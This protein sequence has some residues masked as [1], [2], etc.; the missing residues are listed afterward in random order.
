[1]EGIDLVLRM[2]H[3]RDASEEYWQ[4][5]P[6]VNAT[7]SLRARVPRTPRRVA[8]VAEV[9][10]STG[11]VV[12]L[13][14]NAALNALEWRVFRRYF[15]SLSKLMSKLDVDYVRSKRRLQACKARATIEGR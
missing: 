9:N 1:M 8:V 4:V 11:F 14:F 10:I 5:A 6:L 2:V 7:C 3:C 15:E 13:F 12:K